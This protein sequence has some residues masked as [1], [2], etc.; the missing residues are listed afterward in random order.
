MKS[1]FLKEREEDIGGYLIPQYR[2]KNLQMPIGKYLDENRRNTDIAFMI[3]GHAFLK[4]Y[5]S[6]VFVDLMYIYTRYQPQA[7][8]LSRREKTRE[9]LELIGKTIE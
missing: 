2:K 4:L 8:D 3:G 6:R 1:L 7:P 9:D 5:L